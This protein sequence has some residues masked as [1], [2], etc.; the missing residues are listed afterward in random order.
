MAITQLW[1][2]SVL[3][4]K[5][6][7]LLLLHEL[8]STAHYLKTATRI[9][10][11]VAVLLWMTQFIAGLGICVPLDSWWSIPAV[12]GWCGIR[13]RA[14][15]VSTSVVHTITDFAILVLPVPC[16]WALR[17]PAKTRVGL[18]LVFSGGLM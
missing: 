1:A 18:I 15:Y 16:L 4:T 17:L 3:S 13:Q 7:I 10:G 5:L 12:T 9:L 14:L 6:T 8:F 11:V 2:A